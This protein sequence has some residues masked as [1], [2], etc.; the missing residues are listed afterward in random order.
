MTTD[1]SAVTFRLD[2]DIWEDVIYDGL[3]IARCDRQ[4]CM[5]CEGRE[6]IATI[7]RYI[8]RVA[9]TGRELGAG[10]ESALDDARF[11]EKD[12]IRCAPRCRRK[13]YL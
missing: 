10:E 4:A 9:R 7:D 12:K 6:A 2:Q 11:A 3:L 13:K 8:E 1:L 5:A